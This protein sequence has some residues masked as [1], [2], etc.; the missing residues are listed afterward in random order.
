MD[1]CILY[2]S[3][4]SSNISSS[5]SLAWPPLF[6]G[7]QFRS[8]QEGQLTDIEQRHRPCTWPA[9]GNHKIIAGF[10]TTHTV[11]EENNTIKKEKEKKKPNGKRREKTC[12]LEGWRRKRVFS[13][14]DL[15]AW[16]TASPTTKRRTFNL[17]A[18]KARD[19][20][21]LWAQGG[22]L[23]VQILIPLTGASLRVLITHLTARRP[24]ANGLLSVYRLM[25]FCQSDTDVD[26]CSV[27]MNQLYQL[28][29]FSYWK[30]L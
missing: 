11:W 6:H 29:P 14:V 26:L 1:R 2:K 24:P 28:H 10:E 4:M 3:C 18:S 15:F 17:T 30:F 23:G 27:V 9:I 25:R 21:A 19:N 22:R 20:G 13:V 5:S 12:A 7:G 16:W 8:A